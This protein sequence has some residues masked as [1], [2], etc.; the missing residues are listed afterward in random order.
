M[1]KLKIRKHSGET[2]SGI[3]PTDSLSAVH[4]GTGWIQLEM[5][6]MLASSRTPR[7]PNCH[8][9]LPPPLDPGP[10]NRAKRK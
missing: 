5:A 4:A 9:H 1:P 7:M 6:F 8:H 2:S 10:G 3:A